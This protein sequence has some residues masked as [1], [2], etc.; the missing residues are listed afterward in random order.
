M[1]RYPMNIDRRRFLRVRL[2][3]RRG[4]A[5]RPSDRRL[6]GTRAHGAAR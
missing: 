4:R 1:H 2:S 6:A 3:P 5:R